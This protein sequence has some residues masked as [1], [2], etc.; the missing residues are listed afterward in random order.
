MSTRV[1]HHPQD[2]RVMPQ[3][4]EQRK[5]ST[6]APPGK[7]HRVIG[8]SSDSTTVVH[9]PAPERD[10]DEDDEGGT[11]RTSRRREKRIAR[12]ARKPVITVIGDTGGT[13]P[14]LGRNSF[15]SQG[16]SANTT[17]VHHERTPEEFRRD[18]NERLNALELERDRILNSL[19]QQRENPT[20][21]PP[22]PSD[23]PH[24]DHEDRGDHHE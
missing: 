6:L 9:H 10:D 3:E 18:Q 1:I 20:N 19:A 13:S 17:V 8:A 21:P 5:P 16:G 11:P 2:A 7:E 4:P 15:T 22:P 24:E 14:Q 23:P 12:L